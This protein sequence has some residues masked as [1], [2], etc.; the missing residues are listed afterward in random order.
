MKWNIGCCGFGYKDWKG[1]FYPDKMA[2]HKWFNFYSSQF[3]TVELNS[4][5]Y[6]FPTVPKLLDWYTK[7]PENFSFA[8]K[9]PKLITHFKQMEDAEKLLADFYSTC[10]EGLKEKLGPLLFQFPPKFNYTEKRLQQLINNL[11][12]TYTNVVEFRHSSWWNEEVYTQFA[13]YKIIFCGVSHPLL[14][15]DIIVGGSTIYYRFHGVPSLYYS[16]YKEDALKAFADDIFDIPQIKNVNCYFN[17]TAAHYAINNARFLQ[18]YSNLKE[19]K[20]VAV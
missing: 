10:K 19:E 7:S 9:V 1:V 4:T 5:F 18:E 15:D 6:H 17:N 12:T 20:M 14:P 13:K 8:S 11:D 2:E 3:N 16:S